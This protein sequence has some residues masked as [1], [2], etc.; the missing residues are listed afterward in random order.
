MRRE[1]VRGDRLPGL[2]A[3]Q[4]RLVHAHGE[5]DLECDTSTAGPRECAER[6]QEFLPHRP[7]PTAFTRLRRRHLSDRD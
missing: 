7:L 2:A 4:Y 6:I 5:Y 3:R 1:R